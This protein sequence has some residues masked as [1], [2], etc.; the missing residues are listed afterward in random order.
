MLTLACAQELR[1]SV[2]VISRN[3]CWRTVAL[4]PWRGFVDVEYAAVSVIISNLKDISAQ[5]DVRQR[6]D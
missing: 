5:D 4:E 6:D 3:N 2:V 1:R